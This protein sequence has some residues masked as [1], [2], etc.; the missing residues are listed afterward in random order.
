MNRR[1]RL[2]CW[3]VAVLSFS[4][5][6]RASGGVAMRKVSSTSCQV[7]P[8]NLGLG[9]TTQIV[10]EQTPKVTLFADKKHFKVVTNSSSSRSLAII[11]T[12]ESAELDAFR[13]SK[14]QLPA[15]AE[16]AADLNKSFKTNLFVFFDNNNQM[17]F[18]LQ[19]VD[20]KKADYIL[21]VT[22][23]FNGD[24]VL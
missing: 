2:L 8:V 15:S 5:L 7:I 3:I 14:G 18:E 24:C 4:P 12:I 21:K 16:L 23:V 10:L 17:M 22:E 20:K 13:N 9:T 19:F 11:P 6:R 1:H